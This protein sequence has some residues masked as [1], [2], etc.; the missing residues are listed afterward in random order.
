MGF[1]RS[2]LRKDGVNYGRINKD[3]GKTHLRL[4][5]KSLLGCRQVVRHKV[6]ILACVGSNPATPATFSPVGH[7]T[8]DSEATSTKNI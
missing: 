1:N 6:L 5:F 7:L 3:T 4:P 2:D 8:T